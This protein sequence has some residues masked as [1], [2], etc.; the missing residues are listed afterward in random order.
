MGSLE[1][2]QEP[3]EKYT[4]TFDQIVMDFFLNIL[5]FW[6]LNSWIRIH[7][8]LNAGSGS[9]RKAHMSVGDGGM[10]TDAT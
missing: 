8:D 4:A 1:D 7:E 10:P 3:R 5:Q 6:S 9:T 2:P